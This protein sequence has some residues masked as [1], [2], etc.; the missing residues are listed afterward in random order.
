MTEIYLH[1]LFA[2][3][4]LSSNAPVQVPSVRFRSRFRVCRSVATAWGLQAAASKILSSLWASIGCSSPS[5]AKALSPAW[6]RRSQGHPRP[7]TVGR[8]CS[9][10]FSP[11]SRPSTSLSPPRCPGRLVLHWGMEGAAGIWV[12]GPSQNDD[13]YS[14]CIPPL[15]VCYGLFP[16]N[17]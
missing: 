7:R 13:C 4:G 10:P 14:F 15:L 1:F 5:Q 3:Y 2:H 17:R 16:Y 11:A 9:K 12:S 8:C 6:R